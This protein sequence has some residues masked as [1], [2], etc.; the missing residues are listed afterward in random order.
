[1]LCITVV[2]WTQ[3][4]KMADTDVADWGVT[5]GSSTAAQ[6]VVTPGSSSAA[7]PVVTADTK[8][9]QRIAVGLRQ[10]AKT[11]DED[12]PQEQAQA[13]CETLRLIREEPQ[14]L[15]A[16]EADPVAH[17]GRYLNE[18][19]RRGDCIDLC[20]LVH[21]LRR[22]DMSERATVQAFYTRM[23][24][25]EKGRGRLSTCVPSSE[26]VPED[27]MCSAYLRRE[28]S[29]LER[30]H[31]FLEMLEREMSAR[32]SKSAADKMQEYVAFVDTKMKFLAIVEADKEK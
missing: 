28:I 14:E 17:M 7:Q 16:A 6:P 11:K 19:A 8:T 12:T 26:A 23:I 22:V 21:K 5:P 2:H 20:A 9:L 3:L 10:I 4:F 32:V 25:H 27:I 30:E 24:A 18:R 1:M 31:R 13:I 15:E 29:R